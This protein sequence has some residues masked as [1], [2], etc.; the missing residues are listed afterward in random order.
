VTLNRL[1][2]FSIWVSKVK[3][4]CNVC[5]HHCTF[6]IFIKN[7]FTVINCTRLKSTFGIKEFI[8]FRGMPLWSRVWLGSVLNPVTMGACWDYFMLPCFPSPLY[9]P[10]FIFPFLF[11]L[12]HLPYFPFSF[13]LSSPFLVTIL[14]HFSIVTLA[15]LHLHPLSHVISPLLDQNLDQGSKICLKFKVLGMR[16]K[17]YHCV[18]L[19]FLIP[20]IYLL[21]QIESVWGRYRDLFIEPNRQ[22]FDADCT[23][24]YSLYRTRVKSVRSIQDTWHVRI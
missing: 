5:V 20:T 9:L 24:L 7:L 6:S 14:I 8:G 4:L 21:L 23:C 22:K 16:R 17:Q 18:R 13:I 15:D 2:V 10:N 19:V 11:P 3:S 1:L 12:L